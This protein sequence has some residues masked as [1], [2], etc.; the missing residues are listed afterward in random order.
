[1]KKIKSWKKWSV[2]IP[3]LMAAIFLVSSPMSAMAQAE[4]DLTTDT[5]SPWRGALA[6]I[7]PWKS[8]VG[9]EISMRVFLR[10]NQEPFAGAGVWALTRD[11]AEVAR[12]EI[13][14]LTNDASI[15]AEEKD[16]E[17]IA[18]IHGTFIGRTGE[19]Q[20]STFERKRE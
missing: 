18:D 16:Y 3:V 12:A 10:E 17:S 19:D 4:E 13:S 8:P 7:A 2:I 6:I 11:K 15:A 1:M 9:K 20:Y 5:A 14:A